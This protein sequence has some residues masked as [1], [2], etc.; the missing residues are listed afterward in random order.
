MMQKVYVDNMINLLP[1]DGVNVISANSDAMSV[2]I[3]QLRKLQSRF[4]SA[5]QVSDPVVAAHNAYLA[6]RIKDVLEN[7]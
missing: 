2:V 6:K 1:R 3:A 5:T 7:K 4:G